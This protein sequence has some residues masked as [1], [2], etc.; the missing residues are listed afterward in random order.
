M[1]QHWEEPTTTNNN[2]TAHAPRLSNPPTHTRTHAYTRYKLNSTLIGI[3]VAVDNQHI[4]SPFQTFSVKI[5]IDVQ[6]VPRCEHLACWLILSD[7][8]QNQQHFQ[9]VINN[10]LGAGQF[11]IFVFF[12][13][14]H[15][16]ILLTQTFIPV[17]FI[18]S[19]RSV[20][21]SIQLAIITVD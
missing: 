12:L 2:C 8:H 10:S 13:S 17:S 19:V 11:V 21:L 18:P 3:L 9:Q 16:T 14:F 20:V 4:Q 7:H 5:C 6:R 15:P 1:W